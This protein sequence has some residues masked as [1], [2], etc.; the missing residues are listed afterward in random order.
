MFGAT[1]EPREKPLALLSIKALAV[2]GRAA[3]EVTGVAFAQAF[4][5]ATTVHRQQ[6][7]LELL[8]GGLDWLAELSGG[9]PGSLIS[10]GP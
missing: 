5:S 2:C 8:I 1:G 3:R 9:G 6:G 7:G 10:P 4:R